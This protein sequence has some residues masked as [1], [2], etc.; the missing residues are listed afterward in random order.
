[1]KEL[2]LVACMWL[3]SV[4]AVIWLGGI[5][6]L[7]AVALPALKNHGGALTVEVM[8]DIGKRFTPMAN[9]SIGVL[10]TTGLLLLFLPGQHANV[11]LFL[12]AKVSFFALMVSI[13][14][15]RILV[16]PDKVARAP[17]ETQRLRWQ[18]MS[19]FLVKGNLGL[20]VT[21]LLFTVVA[22]V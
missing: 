20:G 17:S 7:I 1:M 9:V 22:R 11:D 5:L 13:H 12:W 19:L 16:L 15:W 3:H 14:G 10:L 4:A 6:F 2:I 18:R 8:K 21:A